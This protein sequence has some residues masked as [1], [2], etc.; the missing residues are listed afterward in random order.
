MLKE[1]K[2]VFQ[3]CLKRVEKQVSK[4]IHEYFEGSSRKLQTHLKKVLKVFH[5]SLKNLSL[6]GKL[7]DN[8]LIFQRVC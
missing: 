2:K 3:G 8:S 7:M 5:G 6:V 1:V 4:V